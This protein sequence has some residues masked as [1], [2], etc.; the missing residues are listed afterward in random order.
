MTQP[1]DRE[2]YDKFCK[3]VHQLATRDVLPGFVPFTLRWGTLAEPHLY[4]FDPADARA[5]GIG[6]QVKKALLAIDA[7]P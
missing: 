5:N 1:S 3:R 2:L 6:S 7:D 4:T